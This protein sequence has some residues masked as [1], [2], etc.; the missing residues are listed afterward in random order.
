MKCRKD[1]KK[2]NIQCLHCFWFLLLGFCHERRK[3][4]FHELYTSNKNIIFF[5]RSSRSMMNVWQSDHKFR[6]HQCQITTLWIMFSI[7][8]KI[9]LWYKH[10]KWRS[11]HLQMVI[12]VE[13]YLYK[14][15]KLYVTN[16]SKFILEN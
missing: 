9:L 1:K 12:E 13:T 2:W 16:D 11:V 6:I 7:L 10:N 4:I 8:N 14:A 15:L 3:Q 5:Y